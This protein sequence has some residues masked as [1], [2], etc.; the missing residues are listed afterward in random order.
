VEF[1]ADRKYFNTDATIEV[2]DY[3][4]Q[5]SPEE[6]TD[7]EEEEDYNTSSSNND[8]DSEATEINEDLPT[9]ETT[10]PRR[11]RTNS[12]GRIPSPEPPRH[13]KCTCFQN[14]YMFPK[15]VHTNRPTAEQRRV[16]PP[17]GG[18]YTTVSSRQLGFVL[19][20]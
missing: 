5:S 2:S 10:S 11:E 17:T 14:M 12:E 19:Q 20:I 7:A 13:K 9:G 15:H 16:S 1:I 18:T 6:K 3:V 8:G 4:D